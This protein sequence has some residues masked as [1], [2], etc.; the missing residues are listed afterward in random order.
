[1]PL[2][3]T[4]LDSGT[5]PSAHVPSPLLRQ[6]ISCFWSLPS[7]AK[8]GR[9]LPDGSV[10]L[11]FRFSASG[12]EAS[13]VGVS[14]GAHAA[15]PLPN[16]DR[17]GVSFAPGEAS[18]LLGVAAWEYRDS[19]LP[20]AEVLGCSASELVSCLARTK[21]TP[22]RL[23]VVERWLASRLDSKRSPR[24]SDPAVRGTVREILRAQGSTRVRAL[25]LESG[26][27]E[28]QLE[29]RFLERVG[30]RLKLYCRMVRAQA[31]LRAAQRLV[32]KPEWGLLAASFGYSDQ[33]HLIHDFTRLLG[34]TP[35]RIEMSDFYNL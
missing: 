16:T 18:S 28:R 34:C 11:I 23:A 13:I 14:S 5:G 15:H 12:A 8:E 7:V 24:K 10:K 9:I 1:M 27:S 21:D 32:G 26:L 6:V 2:R 30:I 31:A 22:G 33:A 19:T 29:R 4:S 25:S 35:G 20:L 3:N 17:L